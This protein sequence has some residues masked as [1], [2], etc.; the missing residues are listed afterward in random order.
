MNGIDR[1]FLMVVDS[2]GCGSAPD[3]GSFGDEGSNTLNTISYS[4]E[5]D[6]PNMEKM[7]LFSIDGFKKGEKYY[8]EDKHKEIS[9][10]PCPSL[11]TG[12][13]GRFEEVTAGKDTTAGHWEISG[14]VMPKP[15]PT[16]PDGFPK[17]IIE[18]FEK[19]TG[20][21]TLCNLPYSGTEVIKDYGMEHL[22]TGK[23]IVYTSAD[24]VFQIA[25]HEEIVPPEELYRYCRIA[26]EILKGP[27]GVGRVIARPFVGKDPSDFA[28]VGSHRHDFSMLPPMTTML[29]E[30]TAHGLAAIG[31]GKIRD[32]FAGKGLETKLTTPSA[33]NE[34]GMDKTLAIMKEDFKGLCFVNLVETDSIYGHRRDID[35]YAEAVSAFDKRLGEMLSIMKDT[36]VIMITADHGCDPGFKGTDH[37][38]EYIPLLMYGKMLKS[39][40]DLGTRKCFGSIGATILEMFGISPENITGTGFLKDIYAK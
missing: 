3:A 8:R 16:Y 23:L 30:L 4:P 18:E 21:G 29:D 7:G 12:V 33:S 14:L 39:G 32:I 10:E 22:K 37:T 36:D 35:G 9:G 28:R 11:P 6:C 17:E 19:Q 31:V 5:F 27:H 38:R 2:M 40:V 26:R 34:D 24:S 1:V 15:F 25:A 13:F 20:R